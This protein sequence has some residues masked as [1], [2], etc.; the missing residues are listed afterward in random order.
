VTVT[1]LKE[2]T[3]K[4]EDKERLG[5][6]KKKRQAKA[7]QKRDKPHRKLRR[8]QIKGGEVRGEKGHVAEKSLCTGKREKDMK[9]NSQL[10]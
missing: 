1:P 5:L 2:Q 10:N 6:K 4:G 3:K 9:K 8:Y 7:N